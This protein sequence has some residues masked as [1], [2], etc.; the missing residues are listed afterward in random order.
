MIRPRAGPRLQRSPGKWLVSRGVAPGWYKPAPLALNRYGRSPHEPSH[1]HFFDAPPGHGFLPRPN[2]G[3]RSARRTLPPANL[4]WCPSGTKA[5]KHR[6]AR[7]SE[8]SGHSQRSRRRA[9]RCAGGAPQ[10]ISRGQVR[11]RGRG[12]RSRPLKIPLPRRGTA[13]TVPATFLRCPSGA[14]RSSAPQ[15]GG[16]G[17][18]GGP[19]PQLMF[20]DVPPGPTPANTAPPA[21]PSRRRT[22]NAS[23][24]GL[25]AAPE[26]HRRK[27]AGGK[28]APADAAPG[29]GP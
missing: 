16:R 28:S 21:R 7:A 24:D 25:P 15:P 17:P 26:A 2:R 23:S 6:A 9:S 1:S 19:C 11:A 12:P 3:P 18:P 22:R 14:R 5:G 10:E 29:H 4:R 13:G 20:C 8:S 27:L